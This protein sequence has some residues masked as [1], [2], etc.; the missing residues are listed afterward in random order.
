MISEPFFYLVAVPA[1]VL[2]GLSKGGFSGLGLLSMSM[3]SLAVSPVKAAAIMLPILIVQ[4]MVSVWAYR[5]TFDKRL[6]AIMLPGTILGIGF[7]WLIA[8]QVS[9]AVVRLIVGLISVVFVAMFWRRR[10]L[11]TEPAPVPGKPAPGVFWG[12]VAGY[13][14][15]VAHAGGP[16]FQVYVMPLR[17]SPALYAGTNTMFFAATNALKTVPYLALGQFSPENLASSAALFPIAI[18]ATLG[19]VWLIQRIDATRFY[20]VV[21]G[22]TLLVGL[23]LV[24]DA[25]R[26]LLHG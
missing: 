11:K 13:T 3:L 25:V 7:G 8:A 18:V 15:F 10:P 12:A 5:R 4:D 14:S 17:L 20:M 16:P 23:G 22:L 24:T 6:L 9:E 19:G 21:Y 26:E 1:V 2:M